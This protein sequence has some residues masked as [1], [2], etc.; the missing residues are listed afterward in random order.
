MAASIYPVIF[1]EINDIYCLYISAS[2]GHHMLAKPIAKAAP[3][4]PAPAK[5]AP[6]KAPVAAK[7]STVKPAAKS[8]PLKAAS[9]PAVKKV[10]PPAAPKKVAVPV[11]VIKLK[12]SKLVR[13]SFTMPKEEY[14]VIE[15]LKLR[16]GKLGQAV[17][18]SELLRAGIKALAAMT[19]IQFRAGLSNVPTIKTGRPKHVK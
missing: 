13:D 7:S 10:A 19:D 8:A 5:S 15:T 4:A 1:K 9:A 14:A 18:K 17:K 11:E 2:K 12:K 6:T 16:A 3:T